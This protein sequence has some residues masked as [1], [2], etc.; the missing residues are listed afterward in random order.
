M[1]HVHTVLWLANRAFSGARKGMMVVSWFCQIDM[2][3]RRRTVQNDTILGE[4]FVEMA[5]HSPILRG[6]ALDQ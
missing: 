4:K 3:H 1:R 2:P 5:S 6:K